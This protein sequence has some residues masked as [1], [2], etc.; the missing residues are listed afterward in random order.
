MIAFSF[1]VFLASIPP[2]GWLYYRVMVYVFMVKANSECSQLFRYYL[3]S[4]RE[5]KRLDA[6]TRSPMI[7][8][9]SES[10]GGLSTIRAFSQQKIFVAQN[11]MRIDQNQ[12]CYLTSVFINR[13]LAVRL[14]MMGSI[15]ILIAAVLSVYALITSGIDAG[16]VGLVLSYSLNITE[17]LVC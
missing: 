3:A 16:L 13:W 5:L 11:E 2:L 14:E 1:P 4:S 6:A 7:S 10:L 17:T 15:V 9:F 8:W 12:T